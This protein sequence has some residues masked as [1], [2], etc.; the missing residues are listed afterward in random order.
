MTE[1][2]IRWE[3]AK[4]GGWTGHVGTLDPWLFQIWQ[5]DGPDSPWRLD[6]AL[7]GQF[8]YHVDHPDTKALKLH[9]ERWLEEFAASLGAIFPD[10]DRVTVNKT[11]LDA[12]ITDA[13]ANR[14]RCDSEFCCS[15][16]EYEAS[17]TEFAAFV[18]ALDIKAAD[19]DRAPT[20]TEE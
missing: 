14:S 11:A 3:P 7:P 9:A 5:V 10:E 20:T 1:T 13:D 12:F 8:G 4:Y 16:A 19:P 17:E 2:R 6:S 15:V 18:A